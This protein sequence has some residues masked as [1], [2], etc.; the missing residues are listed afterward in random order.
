MEYGMFLGHLARQMGKTTFYGN[1]AGVVAVRKFRI[2]PGCGQEHPAPRKRNAM[3]PI[4]RLQSRMTWEVMDHALAHDDMD[5]AYLRFR[6]DVSTVE[7][8]PVRLPPL[9]RKRPC[10]LG[11]VI[12]GIHGD[13]VCACIHHSCR[14]S[15][16]PA[17]DI[18]RKYRVLTCNGL[19]VRQ[20]H[21]IEIVRALR[22]NIDTVA[23][24]GGNTLVA[25]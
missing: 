12:L 4:Q 18:N 17:P 13:D 21:Q 6:S 10:K 15:T 16:M 19:N 1:I 3:E 8:T 24:N 25:V 9:T 23:G 2:H 14:L 11:P 20:R 5:V 22:R 7:E